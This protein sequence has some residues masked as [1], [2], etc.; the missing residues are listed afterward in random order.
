MTQDVDVEP[1]R[2]MRTEIDDEFIAFVGRYCRSFFRRRALRFLAVWDE[3]DLTNE[4][5]LLLMADLGKGKLPWRM[6]EQLMRNKTIS[7]M[8]TL[9][10]G[11]LAPGRYA[12]R[13][14]EREE[15]AL[16]NAERADRWSDGCT[17]RGIGRMGD[18]YR[19]QGT[20]P[21]ESGNRGA[22]V[23]E[24]LEEIERLDTPVERLK[25]LFENEGSLWTP[26]F[27]AAL[28]VFV[29]EEDKRCLAAQM[30]KKVDQR[31]LE[32]V[33]ANPGAGTADANLAEE[34]GTTRETVSRTLN[35]LTRD[36]LVRRDENLARGDLRDL[37]NRGSKWKYYPVPPTKGDPSEANPE[38]SA[39][40][41]N[42]G[43]NERK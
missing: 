40:A 2:K 25:I 13:T 33:A 6:G 5:I 42:G 38:G 32:W 19:F 12:R 1:E 4:V 34:L 15:A 22:S 37:K 11:D 3:G 27:E 26:R 23:V 43:S 14:L 7:A 17:L 28:G 36:R 8:R 24:M 31:I 18:E 10:I 39:T 30:R 35:Q 16:T 29:V 41:S 20:R 9:V 21:V